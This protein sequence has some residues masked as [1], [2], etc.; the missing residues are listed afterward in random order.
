MLNSRVKIRNLVEGQIPEFLRESYP[1][2]QQLLSEYYK[3]SES[4]GAPLDLLNNI[5]QY[6]K[7]DNLAEIT[8]YSELS[9]AIGEDDDIITVES[10]DGFPSN[11]GLIQI[12][13][14]VILYESKTNTT[15]VNCSRGFS[16]ITSYRDVDKD[17]LIFSIT[18]SDS[19]SSGSVVYNLSNFFLRELFKKFKSQYTPGFDNI[20]FYPGINEK[21]F[22]SR[23]KD[24]YSSKGAITSFEILFKSLYGELVKV[25]KPKDFIVQPSDADY[26]ITRDLVVEQYVGNPENLL[27]LTLFQDQ[28]DFITK[29]SGTI[30][31]IEKIYRNSKEYYQL[32]LDYN[33]D[34]E[35][36]EFTIHPK[37][38]IVS[39]VTENQTYIDV[40]STLGFPPSGTLSIIVDGLEYLVDYSEKS[41]TQFL[42]CSGLPF[43]PRGTK[44]ETLDYAYAKDRF[45]NEVRVKITGVISSLD[46]DSEKTYYYRE[47]D[48][49]QLVSLGKLGNTPKHNEWVFNITPT[50]DVVSITQLTNKINGAARFR[51]VTKDENIFTVGD[52]AIIKSNTGVVLDAFVI[53]VSDKNTIDIN[54]T[55]D[56]DKT[57]KYTITK[58]ISKVNCINYSELNTVS[59]DI[60]NVYID[61][62]DVYV[63]SPSLPNYYNV[64]LTLKDYSITFGGELNGEDLVLG[65]H[66]FYTGD[67]IFYKSQGPLNRLN[68]EDGIYY[69][70]KINENT[71]K[72]ASSKSNLYNNIFISLFGTISDNKIQL[73]RFYNLRPKSQK[74][75]RKISP[76]VD[77]GITYETESGQIGIL[78]NGVEIL[79]YKSNDFVYYGEIEDLKVTSSG[80]SNYDIINPPIL[81]IEDSIG[82]GATGVCNIVGSLKKINIIDGGYGY[83]TEPKVTIIGG[84][85]SGASAKANLISITNSVKFNAGDQYDQVNLSNNTIG[86]TTDHRFFNSERIVYKS[87]I[88]T[89]IGGLINDSIYYVGVIDRFTIKLYSNLRDSISGVNTIS[90]ATYGDGLHTIDS[91]EKKKKI[92]SIDILSPG[93]DYQNKTLFFSPSDVNIYSDIITIKNHSYKDKEIVNY[94]STNNLISGLSSTADYYVKVIDIDHIKLSLVGIGTSISEDF[95]FS[96]NRFAT[97][98]TKGSGTHRLVYKPISISIESPVGVS[99]FPGQD[100][101]AKVQPI[102]RGS[103]ASISLSNRGSNYG[104]QE[105]I[106][107]N[108]QPSITLLNGDSALITPIVSNSG[109]II[110]AIINN[111]GFYYNSP[112][113]LVV[114]GDGVGC[115]LTPVIKDGKIIE[116]KIINTGF[117]YNKNNTFIRVLSAGSGAKFETQIKNWRINLVERLID[118]NQIRFDDGLLSLGKNER[119]GLQYCHSYVPRELRRKSLSTSLG[120]DGTVIYRN[121]LLNDDLTLKY[122][123]PIIGWA[124]DGNPIYGPYGYS[125]REGG[126]VKRMVSGY[127][128]RPKPDR[129]ASYPV[130]LFVEDYEFSGEGDLDIYNGRYCKTPEFPNGVYAYFSTINAQ[131]DS[132]GIFNGFLKPVFPYFI[133]NYYKS[134]PVRFNFDQLSNQDIIDINQTKWLRNTT[135]YSILLNNSY[136]DG[137]IQPDKFVQSYPIVSSAVPGFVNELK[138][139][140]F[141]DNYSINDN[142]FFNN[143]GTSGSGAYASIKEISGR[144]VRNIVYTSSKVDNVEL[145]PYNNS[146]T[147]IGFA[148]APHNLTASDLIKIQN[149]S[150]LNSQFDGVYKVGIST[151]QLTLTENIADSSITGIV[152]YINVIGSLTIPD[153]NINDILGI[154]TEQVKVLSVDTNSSR[155]KIRRAYNSTIGVAHSQGI[156]VKEFPRKFFVNVGLTNITNY[157]LNKEIYFYPAESISIPS[158]NILTYSNPVDFSAWSTYVVGSGTTITVNY[159][160]Q[161]APNNTFSAAK[162]QVGI[163]TATEISGILNGP[164]TLATNNYTIS[165]FLK[166]QFGGEIVYLIVE[167]GSN[168]IAQ[169]IVLSS[170]W[171]RY[172]V[173]GSANAGPHNFF[174]G[175]WGPEG[176]TIP[177][178]TFYVWGAQIES[179]TVLTPHIKTESSIVLRS[180]NE[181]GTTYFSNPG[182]GIKEV[183]IPQNSIY[184]PG[185]NLNTGDTLTYKNNGNSSIQVSFAT[186]TFPLPNNSEVYAVRYSDTF[187][188]IS[189]IK[190][191]LGTTGSYVGIGT[192]ALGNILTFS[193]YGTGLDHSFVTNYQDTISGDIYKKDAVV[194]TDREHGLRVSD[195]V[196]INII[197]GIQTTVYISY[198]DLNRRMLVNPR[199]F[200]ALNVDSVENLIT[201]ANHGFELGSKVIHNS[202]TP[203]GGL[204]NAQIYYVI[205]ISENSLKLSNNYYSTISSSSEVEFVNITSA[206]FGTLTP[207]NPEIKAIANSTVIFD[208][209]DQSLS[210]NGVSSFDFN[211]YTDSQFKNKFFST[212]SNLGQFNVS[213]SGTIGIEGGRVT[214][215]IDENTP[216]NLYYNLTPINYDGASAAKLEYL[217]DN[218]NIKNNNKFS[219]VNS[220]FS[221]RTTITGVTTNTFRYSLI[222]TPEKSGYTVSEGI[223]TYSTNSSSAI[224]PVYTTNLSSKGRGYRKLPSVANISSGLGTNAIFLPASKTLGKVSDVEIR[225]IGFDYPVDYTLRP[226]AKFPNVFKIEPLSK[227]KEIKIIS[228]GVNY[229]V[230]PQLLVLD[231]FT[232]RVNDEV[233]LRYDIGDIEV[234][235]VRNTT[236]LYNVKP[237]II[238]INN[239][240]GTRISN[241]TYNSTNKQVTV[242][243][244]ISYTSEDQFPF[245]VGEKVIVENTNIDLVEGGRGFNS[246]NYGYVLFE[247]IAADANIGVEEDPYIVYSLQN[248]LGP[249]QSPGIYDSFESFGAV[250]PERYFPSF[251]IKLEKDSFRS[252]EIVTTDS[253]AIGIV[254]NYDQANEYLKVRTKYTFK[255][256]DL[257]VGSSSGNK[258]VISSVEG[259]EG[260][261]DVKSNSITRKGWQK[262]TGYLSNGLQRIHDNDYYQYFSYALKSPVSYEVWNPLVS[263]LN[264]TAGFKKFGELSI[265]SFNVDEVGI[266]TSQD[267][268]ALIAISDLVEV[269]DLNCVKDFDVAREKSILI[270]ETLVSNEIIFRLPFLQRYQEFIGNRVLKI[271]DISSQFNND[272][273]SFNLY[274]NNYPIFKVEFNGSDPNIVDLADASIN[275]INHYF[276]SGEEIEYIPPDNDFNNAIEIVPTVITGIGTTTKLPPSIY[277]IKVDNQRIRFASS[278]EN[279]LLFNP[280]SIN[281]TSVGIGSTHIFK[282]KIQNTKALITINGTIQTP[283]V[284][285]A[286][287]SSLASSVGIG[288]TIINVSGISSFFGG[289]LIQVNDEIMKISAVSSASTTFTVFRSWMGTVESS[290]NSND[291]IVKLSGTYNIIDN[292][293]NFIEPMWGNLPIGFGTTASSSGEVDYAGLTT[294]SRF[295]GR[296]FI[297]SALN[298]AFTTSFVRAYETNYI[299]DDLSDQFNGITTQFT[300]KQNKL[301]VDGLTAG[302][303]IILIDDIFQGPQRLGNVLTNI[304]GDYK[305]EES[306][307]VSTLGFTGNIAD[308]DL[309][310]DI[311]VNRVPKGGVIVSVGSSNGFGYQPLVSAGGTATV[312]VAGTIQSI[313]IGNSGSGYRVGIQTL[314]NIG[315]QTYSS[316]IPN[317]TFVG[318]ATVFNG[319]VIGPVVIT[320]PGSGFTSSNPPEVIF[321]DPLSYS[322]I[323]LIYSSDSP[324]NGIGTGAVVDVVVG[325]GSSVI[326]FEFKNYGYAYGQGDILTIPVGGLTGIPS[327]PGLP[328]NQFKVLVDSTY[329]SKFSGWNVGD[330]LVLDNID[331]FFNGRRRLFPLSINGER[332]SFFARQNSGIDLQSN[333]LVFV[334]D[335]LQ[336]PGEGYTFTG[337]SVL[338]FSEAPRGGVSGIST[339]G[340][341][342]KLLIYTGTQ[343][344]DVKQVDVLPT[345]KIG[346]EV[347]LY[348]DTDETLNQD[349]RLV[350]DISAADTI[351]TNNYAGQG[352]VS[353]E[354][355]ERPISWCKQTVDKIIDENEV[356][357]D[358]IYY[359]P[360]IIPTTNILHNVGL[361][362]TAIFVSSLRPFFDYPLEGIAIDEKTTIELVSQED[363]ITATAESIISV[364]GTVS[365][366]SVTNPGFGY[367]IAPTVTIQSPGYA[368]SVSSPATGIASISPSGIVTS[369]QVSFAGTGYVY[370]PV[371]ALSIS[372]QGLGFPR[373]DALTNKFIKAKLKSKT[374]IG[375]NATATITLN[376]FTYNITTLEITDG[377][378]NYQLGDQ[379]FIDTFDNVGLAST[380]RKYALTN[381]MEFTVSAIKPPVVLISPP[382]RKNESIFSVTYSGDYGNIVGIGTTNVG[383]TTGV[384]FDFYIPLNSVLRR[385]YSIFTSGIQT[386]QYFV[387]TDSSIGNS[388]VSLTSSNNILGIGSTCLDNVYEVIS[389]SL[390][391]RYIPSDGITTSVVRVVT[392][393]S[394]Y[395]GLT[396][397]ASTAF[398]GN[399]SWGRIDTPIRTRPIEFNTQT[400]QFVGLS[401]NPIVRRAFPLKYL[402][403]IV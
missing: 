309:T 149:L 51:L 255:V 332:I 348:N 41:S 270:D 113:E 144:S 186:T 223:T 352:V 42:N 62:D 337:G 194:T 217:A 263:N 209:S 212:L 107:Y 136:Y 215:I 132:S 176:Y 140:N 220:E 316:G 272:Q 303:A 133:G 202:Q 57:L 166:G 241:I 55:V 164:V 323:P 371:E 88:Q 372:A 345:V 17:S 90:F 93:K 59:S 45:G 353:D 63:T 32:S 21:L 64:P 174:V 329:R 260:I 256:N 114:D 111:R 392:K 189:T 73:S 354:L 61:K 383:I 50:Y 374:G 12:D 320:N 195:I 200:T 336:T 24:F 268:G 43:V 287:T 34:T 159:Y 8:Y 193:G 216:K 288:S 97:L 127:V 129:P 69:V 163:V 100:F 210:I 119:Y 147:F 340:D 381:P 84:N 47:D 394:N 292:T 154:G 76:T 192:T 315:V 265:E 172:S 387:V 37:T 219:I 269:V 376:P 317:I 261:F 334:N 173:S 46:Y 157:K 83:T 19:H 115:I 5:D 402:G 179:G 188:G 284:S 248:L 291:Q 201:I 286:V 395:N 198:D 38:I 25:I 120:E 304:L 208:L 23:I 160:D 331:Q 185:H 128:L 95:Y 28:T 79:N 297:R 67:S 14:E 106:N 308:Y 385:D 299:F 326:N 27:N 138:V 259:A 244:G 369:I 339:R 318:Y 104:D 99:T 262:E 221:K 75:V 20:D 365:S 386:G 230:P 278:P 15:F 48:E 362:S 53:S 177:E 282:S 242:G 273:R 296:V 170:S 101:N 328:F 264:H 239:P 180:A 266:S 135:P 3:S 121:D 247:I 92:S 250:T 187:I 373:I 240:N 196:D 229:F 280:E 139:V 6:V 356:A 338:R 44:L 276:V 267:F 103:I 18:N 232:G 66:P 403:Y 233:D 363:L 7:L 68:I 311:N 391:N 70:K 205:P 238:P 279:A 141:G 290:H 330:F 237:V 343:T 319:N 78:K 152:T 213:K 131:K 31:K 30:T 342:C 344:I 211:L 87:G 246:A 397:I 105:I 82:F 134:T 96:K 234:T 379:L 203:S 155:I 158:E 169:Q 243:L 86:F 389:T 130:G 277:V 52:P 60:Q 399:Y 359:E 375:V 341:R 306:A 81:H 156:V 77:E 85:G 312:S 29:A 4:Q 214:L 301:D 13:N 351:I 361:G 231:G 274:S 22:I 293:I 333:L 148:T 2:F 313:S 54:L 358:R 110:D 321:D 167:D 165:A 142:I 324:P 117:G 388:S 125:D 36:F 398:Y 310:S 39:D 10:T 122:H 401:S 347:Q 161:Q 355:Y 364:G 49:I 146:G 126:I 253:G 171:K 94:T 380:Q 396:G 346:D 305:I 184:L 349:E 227:F 150:N 124:Y 89:S 123:S 118:T 222:N 257:I 322:N 33:P 302:N 377:G 199:S 285:T 182:F 98:A 218:F 367:T 1:E 162:V 74:L 91:F 224:G 168:F 143:Q 72:L 295:S 254:Q 384:Q 181:V 153:L 300:L 307:G 382:A 350:I 378:Y 26:R 112:P 175:G 71:I 108:R 65:D 325:Q 56:V 151:N 327:S 249:N 335:I 370:G 35:E 16:G 251:D 190:V 393:I 298:Q 178:S 283:I 206:S 275:L 271:D 226:Y 252:G 9:D 109:Q 40:D 137:V 390:V 183:I 366:I 236:G 11:Y 294:S 225:D 360:A 368:T 258:G 191:G 314:V 289:D 245:I 400:N 197:S 116:V 204:N 281:L 80:D 235:I 58:D 357:K 145:I 228:P 102:F 207:I